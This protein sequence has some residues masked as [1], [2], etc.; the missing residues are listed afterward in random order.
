MGPGLPRLLAWGAL[1][2][3]LLDLPFP[4]AGPMP[5]WRGAFAFLA[6]VPLLHAVLAP[7]TVS[8]PRPVLRS[9]L[10]GYSCGVVWYG[11]NCYW[12]YA[13]MHFY[14]GLPAAVAVGI[15]LLFSLILGLY[16]ALFAFLLA[17]LCR[18]RGGVLPALV[19]VPVLWVAVEYLAAHFTQVPWD[20]LG[21][22]QVDNFL[23]TPLAPFTGVY[24]LSFVIAAVNAVLV[25]VFLGRSPRRRMRFLA[26]GLVLL[27]GLELGAYL[28]PA[29]AP[30]E[31]K[32]VLLQENLKVGAN[33]EDENLFWV[34]T[35]RD[36]SWTRH[37]GEFLRLSEA[38]CTPYLLGM[39]EPWPQHV[40]RV[41]PGLPPQA[42]MVAWP[43]APSPF[44]ES[45][46]RFAKLLQ[47][48]THATGATA[49]VGA[50]AIE[51]TGEAFN[52]AFILRP[53]GSTEGRYDKI[54]LVPWG[55]YVPFQRFFSFAGHLTQNVA[56]FTHGRERKVFALPDGHRFSVFICYEAV[57][58]SEIRLFAKNGAEAFVNLSDD[59]WYGDT[60]AP[61]QHL[62]MARMR[63][64]EN[65]RWILRDT[66]SG[67]TAAI[68]PEGRVTESVA[69]HQLTALTADYGY[70]SDLTF[71]TRYGDVFAWLCEIIA[72][73]LVGFA[74][75]KSAAARQ[76][77]RAQ[78]S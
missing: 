57:F 51:P 55:E 36:R 52:S 26:G 12:I 34:D 3:L 46:P 10:A 28:H 37:T 38:T 68:D 47:D 60:S 78:R 32:A 4:L 41:C 77:S 64:I 11:L 40:E 75:R 8:G 65:R 50:P 69:R 59:G 22:S 74:V 48:L 43:E 18:A 44:R 53:D 33:L 61:W 56:S 1:S 20:Q 14:G 2:G 35:P 76:V 31:A 21:Y 62:N 13:T 70:R 16:F 24:G 67:V 72:I 5:P 6:L 73:A 29:A 42:T 39:P 71:Y 9:A 7:G 63:A 58:A 49:I 15:L 27:C 19:A 66:N 54:H 17:L 25:G 30:R 45:D 23:L